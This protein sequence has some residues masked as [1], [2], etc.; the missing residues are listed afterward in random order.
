MLVKLVLGLP[1]RN[2]HAI[3]SVVVRAHGAPLIVRAEL[4]VGDPF[5]GVSLPFYD[6]PFRVIDYLDGAFF[7]ANHD[8]LVVI[9]DAYCPGLR[10]LLQVLG[11]FVLLVLF[12]VLVVVELQ[13]LDLAALLRGPET[14]GR[15]VRARQIVVVIIKCAESPDFVS[16]LWKLGKLAEAYLGIRIIVA[17][18]VALDFP[19]GTVAEITG[20]KNLHIPKRFYSAQSS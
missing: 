17:L 8:P 12:P 6:L 18:H 7:E 9:R 3:D 19:G 20:T 2:L 15:V 16:P 1:G 14:E 11:L 4:D 13:L 10:F 5:L